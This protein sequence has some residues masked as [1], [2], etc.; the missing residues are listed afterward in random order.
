[1]RIAVASGKGGTG[2]TTVAVNLALALAAAGQSVTYADCDVEEPNGQIFLKPEITGSEAIGVPV[3]EVNGEKCSACGECGR[4]CSFSAIVCIDGSP[5]T[6]PELCKGCG[7][8]GLVCQEGAISEGFREVGFVETG[9]VN[10]NAG[11]GGNVRFVQG[12]LRIGE[13]QSP[14]LIRGVKEMVPRNGITV[15][16]SPPGT[17]CPVIETVRDADLVLLVT[18]PTPFGL[19]DLELVVNMLRVL[20][21]RAAVALN[22]CDRG[23]DEVRHFC[24]DEGLEIVFELPEDRR[25]AGICAEGGLASQVD[26]HYTHLFSRLAGRILEFSS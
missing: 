11:S 12:R 1:M 18:E 26:P 19:N 6:Y 23:D 14:P 5:L 15:I 25:I 13:A 4:I 10:R 7:G 16:D 9:T 17:S 24:R 2:K 8:C 3:P 22:R 21:L 20:D